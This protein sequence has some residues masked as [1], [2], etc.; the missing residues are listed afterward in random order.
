[1]MSESGWPDER[2]AALGE[3]IAKARRAKGWDQQELASRSGNSA[4]TISNY[5]R[6]R[7]TRSRRVPSGVDRVA[8][9]LGWMP[10]VPRRI[11]AGEDPS[12]V[13]S[14]LSLL[15]DFREK[16]EEELAVQPEIDVDAGAAIAALRSPL[17]KELENYGHHAQD[18]F[19]RQVK[20]YRRLQNVSI[21]ELAK[22]VIDLGG[23]LSLDD[24]KQM[25]KG[26]RSP[27]GAE[28]RV[29]AQA[30]GTT[31]NWLL[32]S[33]SSSDAPDE[34][35]APATREEL[36]AEE[37]AVKRRIFVAASDLAHARKR[38]IRAKEQVEVARRQEELAFMVLDKLN[39]QMTEL[40]VDYQYVL[41]RIDSLRAASGEEMIKH[42]VFVDPPK[43]DV[44]EGSS[45]GA[46]LA[47]ARRRLGL[48]TEQV[49]AAARIRPS[50]LTAIER[51]QFDALGGAVHARG[52]IRALAQAYGVDAGSL[53]AQY[54]VQHGSRD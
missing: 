3:E 51:D 41:G 54:D 27:G 15:D 14:Q 40:Q 43:G 26:T 21:E 35:K 16:Y 38:H 4:N 44:S 12:V 10:D 11:L 49:A 25:E 17:Q 42:L 50:V 39:S 48:T 36:E 46:K 8:F 45:I 32:D 31:V 20:R 18:S 53:I 1:M 22:R 19:V 13:L 33:V 23:G 7:S 5:E 9:A 34:M 37:E 47:E 52:H 29:I 30:L 6:G 2:W 24:L 28:G